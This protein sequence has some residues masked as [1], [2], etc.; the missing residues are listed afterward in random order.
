MDYPYGPEPKKK[1][2][3]VVKT[4]ETVGDIVFLPD[5]GDP[6][7]E[8]PS[9]QRVA[10]WGIERW[11]EFARSHGLSFRGELAVAAD[12]RLAESFEELRSLHFPLNDVGGL[13]EGTWNAVPFMSYT[14]MNFGAG[15][16]HWPYRFVCAKLP[17]HRPDLVHDSALRAKRPY[18][19]DWYPEFADYESVPGPVPPP[20]DFEKRPGMLARSVGKGLSKALDTFN[21]LTAPKLHSASGDDAARIAAKPYERG[22]FS[23]DWAVK[24]RW[25]VV[26][27]KESKHRVPMEQLSR[28]LDDFVAVKLFMDGP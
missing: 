24:G 2:H 11:G 20:K 6:R 19:L 17:D 13:C 26:F 16:S 12:P 7:E 3:P 18:H 21:N 28:F 23:R 15:G 25:L 9:P 1:T 4:L 8:P 10:H 5:G 22:A 27:E 14:A